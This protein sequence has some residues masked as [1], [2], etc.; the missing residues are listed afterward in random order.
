M[1]RRILVA[2][3]L[4]VVLAVAVWFYTERVAEKERMGKKV[5]GERYSTFDECIDYAK[6][7]SDQ[8]EKCRENGEAK[9]II[10][11]NNSATMHQQKHYDITSTQGPVGSEGIPTAISIGDS[12]RVK[13]KQLTAKHIFWT[14]YLERAEWG[15]RSWLMQEVITCI[16][17]QTLDDLPYK[18]ED[19][20][21]DRLWIS[22]T[23]CQVQV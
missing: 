7:V 14:R 15:G 13:D 9:K 11:K 20:R 19:I 6:G 2:F 12:V 22:V 18:D 3:I 5:S 10:V 23:D 1:G 17:V 21:R 4:I 8:M 16:I